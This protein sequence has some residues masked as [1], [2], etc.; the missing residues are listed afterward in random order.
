MTQNDFL[1][2]LTAQYIIELFQKELAKLQRPAEELIMNDAELCRLLNIS[3]RTTATWRAEGLIA[4]Q[5]VGG[6][7]FYIYADVLTM[8]RQHRKDALISQRKF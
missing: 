3:K 8:I 6:I 1:K 2:N 4:Y 7:V 5:K